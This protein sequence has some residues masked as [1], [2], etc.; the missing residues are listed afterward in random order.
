MNSR[1]TQLAVDLSFEHVVYVGWKRPVMNISFVILLLATFHFL[2]IDV[3]G[4]GSKF[5]YY[6]LISV[7]VF[8]VSFS[9]LY[10][11]GNHSMKNIL[12]VS[13][14]KFKERSKAYQEYVKAEIKER[15]NDKRS[16]F[17]DLKYSE[18]IQLLEEDHA[19]IKSEYKKVFLVFVGLTSVVWYQFISKMFSLSEFDFFDKT[20]YLFFG[21]SALSA[22]IT[23]LHYLAKDV[24]NL[25]TKLSKIKDFIQ[26]I[27]EVKYDS[28]RMN[29]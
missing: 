17:Y 18:A 27:E 13:F 24:V 3:R 7:V 29:S 16:N 9:I 26:L 25:T 21:L 23:G 1:L 15:F 2:L 11:L 28:K 10:F 22:F 4:V 20:I 8:V 5:E 19:K 14:W 6:Q 12:Y